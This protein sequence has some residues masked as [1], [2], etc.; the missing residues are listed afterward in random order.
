MKTIRQLIDGAI[1]QIDTYRHPDTSGAED[2]LNEIIVAAGLGNISHD[3]LAYLDIQDGK[4]CIRTEY[5][6]R[7]CENSDYYEFPEAILDADDPI[8]AATEWGLKKKLGC[9]Q[10]ERDEAR[11]LLAFREEAFTN[12]QKALSEFSASEKARA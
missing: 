12:A 7:G 2:K 11:R 4:V 9:A 5:S 1:E 10:Q 6:V 8:R 3:R